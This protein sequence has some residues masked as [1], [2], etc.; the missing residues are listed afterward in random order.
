[1]ENMVSSR[2]EIRQKNRMDILEILR[3]EG[4]SSRVDLSEQLHIAKA[5]VTSIVREMTRAGELIERGDPTKIPAVKQRG[6]RKIMLDINEN[7]KLALG[8]V[9]DADSLLVGL[10]NLKGQTLGRVSTRISELA[11]H[12]V[13]ECIVDSCAQ[14]IRDNCVPAEKILGLG[15]C[16]GEEGMLRI[17][18]VA[19]EDALVRLRRDLSYALPL[20]VITGRASEGALMAQK[21]F[22]G[23]SDRNLLMLRLG[24]PSESAV[25]MDGRIYLGA[26]RRAGGSQ[27]FHRVVVGETSFQEVA[28][29][30]R[31]CEEILDL[32]SVCVFGK[33][34]EQPESFEQLAIL[35]PETKLRRGIVSEEHRYL[36]GCAVVVGECFYEKAL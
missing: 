17:E 35:L 24:V 22:A 27:L 4:P 20:P 19:R 23:E 15:V 2:N 31:L 11:Y 5:S 34:L 13:L 8:A 1:M 10:S 30:I 16:V 6:R 25:M 12:Q 32:D 18:T 21:Y 36:C 14:L 29:K 9:L 3:R 28:A 26:H 7:H 33:Y